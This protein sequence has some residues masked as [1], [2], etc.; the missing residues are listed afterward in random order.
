[1]QANPNDAAAA[2]SLPPSPLAHLVRDKR[3]LISVGAGG[4]GKTTTAAVLGLMGARWGR[5][6]LVM[7]I[8]PARRLADSLGLSSIDQFERCVPAERAAAIG[9]RD[10]L[11]HAMMLDQK[12]TFDALIT[13]HA[14]NDE[15]RTRI[16]SNKLYRELSTRLSGGQEYAAMEKLYEV[17]SSDRYDLLV[18]DTPPTAN[19]FDFL[20]APRKMVELLDSPA[21]RIFVKSYEAAGHFS[22]RLISLGG[23]YVFKRL[24]R[25]VGG[26]FLDDVAEFFADMHSLLDG[27]RERATAVKELLAADSV[28][29]VIVTAPDP[30]SLSQA[31]LFHQRL[32]A[33]GLE[34]S[35]FVINR[36]H[37]AAGLPLT[38]ARLERALQELLPGDPALRQRFAAELAVAA[39]QVH[40]LAEQDGRAI[41][42]FRQECGEQLYVEVP[43][44]PFDVHD[45]LGLRR[46]ESYL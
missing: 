7:T 42:R 23:R 44:L 24:A 21:V 29:F 40:A 11:L 6:T 43:L 36:V 35:A 41:E 12:E 8:D 20:E 31:K 13:R 26:E 45:M 9:L 32:Q 34:L 17:A 25:F 38:H 39:G 18:L 30:R 1:M 16:L 28:G 27:F 33:D 19:A 5:R 4:V 46:L 2:L 37:Q 14:P 3:I 15:V 22:L 10:G